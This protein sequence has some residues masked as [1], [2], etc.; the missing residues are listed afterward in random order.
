MRTTPSLLLASFLCGVI[1]HHAWGQ[2]DYLTPYA[3]TTIAGSPGH[4]GSADGTNGA[5]SFDL[6]VY[7]ICGIAVDNNSGSVYVSDIG[8]STIR[9][10]TPV[11]TNWVV[12]TIAGQPGVTGNADG[13]NN[14]ATFNYPVGLTMD[15]SGNLYVLDALNYLVREISPMGTNWVTKTVA[16]FTGSPPPYEWAITCDKNGNLFTVSSSG[17]QEISP[18]NNWQVVPIAGNA[19]FNYLQGITVDTNGNLY[20]VDTL[21][22]DVQE[23]TPVGT[24]WMVTTIAGMSGVS[25]YAD[26]T[27]N[28]TLLNQP[29][30]IA[31]DNQ[32][33]L[34]VTDSGNQTIR[35][36]APVGTNWVA[37]TIAGI[38]GGT[39]STDGVGINA[40]FNYPAG[41]ALDS[42][43]NFYVGDTAN[44]TIR[45]GS[46]AKLP[47]A[48]ARFGPNTN[49]VSWPSAASYLISGGVPTATNWIGYNGAGHVLQS[50]GNLQT[51]NWANYTGAVTTANGTNSA[52]ITPVTGNLFFR[53]IQ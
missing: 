1:A 49:L 21:A 5:A 11:G 28:S 40:R 46:V 33:N 43:G 17:I 47:L 44:D 42:N 41:V 23:L 53:L 2:A 26:G 27:N 35:K 32:G 30:S 24:N 25:G 7:T 51:T 22:P 12:T 50:N 20:V 31:L 38:S 39:G 6:D 8:N 15:A 52:I 34:Y 3:V 16:A 4:S 36:L 19:A 14:T 29:V 45:M 48:I 18:T 9:R 37:S 13:T 10:L